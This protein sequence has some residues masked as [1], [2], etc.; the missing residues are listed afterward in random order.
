MKEKSIE[1]NDNDFWR[2]D[3]DLYNL[4][5]KHFKISLND[6]EK[7]FNWYCNIRNKIE[8]KIVKQLTKGKR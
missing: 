5:Q 2:L 8:K 4:I 7:L 6:D 1:L 3:T